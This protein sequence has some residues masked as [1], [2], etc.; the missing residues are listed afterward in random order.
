MKKE[1]AANIFSTVASLFDS[2]DSLRTRYS[3][4]NSEFCRLA[5]LLTRDVSISFS[6]ILPRVDFLIRSNSDKPGMREVAPYVHALRFRLHNLDGTD[7]LTLSENFSHDL[8][9]LARWTSILLDVSIPAALSV[10]FPKIRQR[11]SGHNRHQ[12]CRRLIVDMADE[13]LLSCRSDSEQMEFVKVSLNHEI[14]GTKYDFTYLR[15]SIY[16][17]SQIN[18]ISGERENDTFYPE[19]IVLEPDYLVD[20]SG[21]AACFETYATSPDVALINKIKPETVSGAALLGNFSGELLDEA[22]HRK[23]DKPFDYREAIK[24]FSSRNALKIAAC[25]DMP[26]DFHLLA[27]AQQHNIENAIRKALPHSGSFKRD[28]VVLEPSFF[29]EAL[30]L[31]GRMDMLQTDFSLLIEQK[32]GKGE[33]WRPPFIKPL[34][35]EQHYVQLLLYQA[36]LHYGFD[37]ANGRINSFLLYSKYEQPLL[38]LGNSPRLLS[39]AMEI[40]NQIAAREFEYASTGFKR[41]TDLSPD[42]LNLNNVTG[43]LWEKFTAPQLRSLL[44]PLHTA[45]E[46]TR[47]YVLR[48]MRFIAMEHMCAKTGFNSDTSTSGFS[49]AWSV[50]HS[51]KKNAGDIIDNLTVDSFERDEN[52]SIT[53]VVLL[54]PEN[55]STDDSNFR[56]GDIVVLYSYREGTS[57]DMRRSIAIRPSVTGIGGRE[58]KLKLRQPQSSEVLLNLKSHYAIEHDYLDSATRS[59]YRAVYSLLTAPDRRVKLILGLREPEVDKSITLRGD[60][61]TFNEPVLKAKQ[62]RDIFMI[63]G[64]PGTGKTSHGLVNILIEELTE[65]KCSVLLTAYTNRAVDEICS[66]LDSHGI[67]YIRIGYEPGCA[68]QHRDHLLEHRAGKRS[69]INDFRNV[70]AETRV[71]VGTTQAFSASSQIFSIKQFSLA[72]VDEASQ[73]LEPNLLNLLCAVNNGVPAIGRFVLIGDHKQLPAVVRQPVEQSRV[74][75]RLLDKINLTDCRRSFFERYL[76]LAGDQNIHMLKSQGRMH[77]QIATIASQMFYG[78]SLSAIPLPHQKER[79]IPTGSDTHF[80]SMLDNSRVSFVNVIPD[81]SDFCGNANNAEATVI[82]EVMSEIMKRTG[83]RFD[84]GKTAGVIVP[85]RTQISAVRRALSQIGDQRLMSVSVDTVERYQ[86]SQRDYI[87]YGFT[88]KRPRQLSFLTSSRFEE[89]GMIIDRKLNVAITRARSHMIFVGDRTLLESDHLFKS[90]F[91]RFVENIEK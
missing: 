30:G 54:T 62:S 84:P 24:S 4:I 9:T 34:H 35:K 67:D 36:L 25:E 81:P 1:L 77:E 48:F 12:S 70:I 73:I 10:K 51:D 33:N 11:L 71:I 40:R 78:N 3:E 80:G 7:D 16:A 50:P 75:D 5:D 69:T 65:E 21:I 29:C 88:V 46:I 20:I 89:N 90:L 41:L 74:D 83:D 27:Q 6:G 63:I 85:Y 43:T 23:E 60:Y 13:Q 42:R 44:S 66:Q 55:E 15:P 39:K 32:S 58:I 26:D 49:G 37:I 53:S 2:D 38:K 17:G 56:P 45:D 57:P 47:R 19:L 31:Q 61:G 68:P 59:Q 14:A 76:S 79:L 82:A 72:I 86:G 28:L 87:I 8:T 64:P 52:G 18:I 22:M 91:D